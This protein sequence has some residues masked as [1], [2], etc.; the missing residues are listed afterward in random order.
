VTGGAHDTLRDELLQAA[1]D[2]ALIQSEYPDRWLAPTPTE[3]V[4]IV[5]TVLPVVRRYA[6]AQAAAERDRIATAIETASISSTSY[7]DTQLTAAVMREAAR[8]ARGQP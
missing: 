4:R 1:L 8:I 6:D 2:T 5:D 3:A 7:A